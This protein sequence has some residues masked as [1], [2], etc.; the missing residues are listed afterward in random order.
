MDS[1][2]KRAS[3]HEARNPRGHVSQGFAVLLPNIPNSMEHLWWND[4]C[5]LY[6]GIPRF[7]E[8]LLFLEIAVDVQGKLVFLYD[9]TKF[10]VFNHFSKMLMAN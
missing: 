8:L 1:I 9:R 4:E 6:K 2:Q 5:R 10:L 3:V 7:F